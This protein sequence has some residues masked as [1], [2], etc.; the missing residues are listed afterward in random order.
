MPTVIDSLI[1]LLKLD[2]SSFTEGQRQAAADL[3]KF[4]EQLGAS[5][6]KVGRKQ[7]QTS[8]DETRQQK[9]RLKFNRDV[10]ESYK[11]VT[12]QV[13]RLGATILATGSM[14]DFIKSTIQMDAGLGRFA[15]RLNLN[16]DELALWV[17][18]VAQMGVSTKE[19]AQQ[20][21]A[22]A[23]TFN[24]IREAYL[25]RG[26]TSKV[27]ILQQ[28]GIASPQALE[29]P[30]KALDA[31]HQRLVAMHMLTGQQG[32]RTGTFLLQQLGLSP[33]M[34]SLLESPNASFAQIRARAEK[35]AP[36][37]KAQMED[38]ERATAA[39]GRLDDI[40]RR[41]AGDAAGPVATALEH[42]ADI[43][44]K[45]PGATT[46]VVELIAA[47]V[48]LRAAAS[49]TALLIG[50]GGAAAAAGGGDAVAG[51]IGLGGILGAVATAGMG[52]LLTGPIG[53][54]GNVGAYGRASADPAHAS[55]ADL[56]A[57]ISFAQ[58]NLA[59]APPQ[60]RG[61]AAAAL[62][63]L[64]QAGLQRWGDPRT[65]AGAASAGAGSIGSAAQAFFQAHG[66]SGAVAAGIARGIGAEGGGL[67][68]ARNGAFG[69]GQWRGERQRALFAFAGTNRPSLEQQLEFMLA[70]F[71][72]TA[73]EKSAP[74]WKAAGDRIR[75]AKT[76]ADA[77]RAY[78]AYNMRPGAG[79]YGD[80]QRAGLGR[81]TGQELA[82]AGAGGR[83]V[84]IGTLVV[85]TRATDARGIAKDLP[86]ELAAQ[87]SRGLF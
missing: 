44:E 35:D 13:L 45:F 37:T 7:K 21:M 77:A 28:L 55:D 49:L 38:S 58:T 6:D 11:K 2:S 43:A 4:T 17:G 5:M 32:A 87:V 41:I 81:P 42:V 16:K 18:M 56:R 79:L 12:D 29:D 59:N 22:A 27:G 40:L 36:A 10:A 20:V 30:L 63:K 85:N 67:G 73:D 19:A 78:L 54:K 71:T 1:V 34:I 86:G 66:A 70:E 68:M 23:D 50:G 64:A 82:A 48:A 39:L 74:Q 80:F 26:D 9:D 15:E 72:G 31:I 65:G 8:D 46:A 84:Q 47:V 24:Q 51:G 75:N 3:G 33:E 14:A 69:I 57:A 60:Y 61:A 25:I 52:A 76:A 83:S 53:Q 62:E